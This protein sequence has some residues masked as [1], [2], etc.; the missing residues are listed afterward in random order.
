VVGALLPGSL[1]LLALWGPALAI[2][3]AAL[4][5]VVLTGLAAW[6]HAGATPKVSPTGHA[7]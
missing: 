3:L 1:C 4:V 7:Q 2:E 6:E 5:T